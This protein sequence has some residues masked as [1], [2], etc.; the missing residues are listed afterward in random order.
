[1]QID[2]LPVG[3]VQANCYIVTCTQTKETAVI[4]PGWPDPSIVKALENR[5][6]QLKA[7]LLTHAHFD[8]MAGN[9]FLVDAVDAPIALHEADLPLLQSKGGADAW[10]IPVQPSPEPTIWLKPEQVV[11]IGA[12]EFKV[13]YTPGHTPGHVSF[14]EENHKV[15]FDGDVL[16]KQGIGRTD[17]PGGNFDDLMDSIKTVLFELP[18]DVTVYPGHGPSTTIGG[19]KQTNPWLS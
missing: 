19:E 15:V 14:Y 16:F 1:M 13:L 18:D 8:H 7:I 10:G 5:Q 12:L 9:A 3:P 17:L 4:D 11:K 2:I 6:S